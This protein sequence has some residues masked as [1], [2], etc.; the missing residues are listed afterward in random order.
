M[1]NEEIIY[2]KTKDAKI[3]LTK[4]TEGLS[5]RLLALGVAIAGALSIGAAFYFSIDESG[6]D[7]SVKKWNLALW[8][9]VF[10][11]IGTSMCSSMLF[12]IFYSSFLEK[13]VLKDVTE[14][15]AK[16]AVIYANSLYLERFERM[17][18][19]FTYPS[20]SSPMPEFQIHFNNILKKSKI[21]KF[22]GEEGGFTAFRIYKLSDKGFLL[23]K[24]ITLLIMDPR[25][26][27]LI[28]ERAKI[29]LASFKPNFSKQELESHIQ[30][31]RKGIYA[32]VVSVFDISHKTR[33]QLGFHT[34]HL[35][36]RS[37]I[38]DDG[39]FVTFYLGGEFPGTAFYSSNTY[40][41]QAFLENFRQ[42]N[43]SAVPTI[44]FSTQMTDNNLLEFLK[45]LD[46]EFKLDE[47]REFNKEL[48]SKYSNMV[49]DT[50]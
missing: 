21:Y 4:E 25:S 38:F 46:C 23:Q 5:R 13:R 3:I 49:K 17:I 50:E 8:I 14:N 40:I 31:M 30:V 12:Y 45:K 32:T 15:A 20:T 33:V 37:E 27:T 18:P 47:L 44:S 7:P 9:Q 10:L 1:G 16:D 26:K 28:R 48:F 19:S 24:D 42:I 41:Y 6:R 11:A 43:K 39:I 22:K 29:D 2:P 36:F 34:E 35:F